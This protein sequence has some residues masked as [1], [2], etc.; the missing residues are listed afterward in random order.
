MILSLLC[1]AKL[2]S[3][4]DLPLIETLLDNETILWP[5]RG[6]VVKN[7]VPGEP[8]L[9]TNYKVQARDVT[10]VAAAYLRDIPPDDIGIHARTSDV[11]LFAV[12]SIGCSKKEARSKALA[13]Y[14]RLAAE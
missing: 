13:A 1:L 4:E 14:R 2:N 5:Q 3:T 9:D 11:T 6:Q 8:P 12:D 7:Q 10:L